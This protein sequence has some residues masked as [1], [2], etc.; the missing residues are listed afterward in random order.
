MVELF[1]VIGFWVFMIVAAVKWGDVRQAKALSASSSKEVEALQKRL[2]ALEQE[3]GLVTH[4]MI[5]L[6][7]EKDFSTK[8]TR[9]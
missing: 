8:L 4:Q 5:E 7:E 1:G 3:M 2:A 6:K 9:G